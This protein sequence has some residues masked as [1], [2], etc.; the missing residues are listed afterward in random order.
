M[1]KRKISTEKYFL[2]FFLTIIIFSLGVLMGLVIEGKRISYDER[3]LQEQELELSSSQLQYAFI[4]S[5]GDKES[6]PTIQAVLGENLFNLE[7]SS[8]KVVEHAEDSKLSDQEFNRL[9]RL[10]SLEQLRY[11]FFA[12]KVKEQC[13]Q[14]FSR[15]IYFYSD[16]EDCKYCREQ[17]VVLNYLKAVFEES[18]L[19]FSLDE[20][21]DEP[22]V[23]LLKKN[24][25]ITEYP[26]L[27]VEESVLVGEPFVS[28]EQ[29][30]NE[31]CSTISHKS[32][33]S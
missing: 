17:A 32:C 20:K 33:V 18:L 14:P 3:L 10:Y 31:I 9:K 2:A 25:N 6:C 23:Q 13:A 24:Y 16:N 30:T 8:R 4:D 7:K 28:N 22:M 15:V 19:V 29:L 12:E 11:W 1:V 27:I 26:T 21:L 5:L